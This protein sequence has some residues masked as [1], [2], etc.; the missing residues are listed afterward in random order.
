MMLKWSPSEGIQAT[1][2]LM[3]IITCDES[4]AVLAGAGAGKT[5]LLAQKA[6]YLF[7][8][9]QCVWPKRI[10]SLTF[11]VEAQLNIE[12]R[13]NKRCGHKA[14]R[15]DSFTFHSFSKSIVDRFK[16]VLPENE[17]PTDNYDIVFN[18]K[19]ANGKNK[20]LMDDLLS[21]AIRILRIR[22]DIRNVFP[23]SYSYVFV[24][25]FQDTTNEQYELLLLLFQNS[26]TKVLT[27]G[28][29]YQSIMLWA[30][31]REAVFTDFL[32]DFSAVRKFMVKNYRASKEIQDV[33]GTVLQYIKEPD[34]TVNELAAQSPNCSLHIFAD[35]HQ[36]ASIITANIKWLISTG[37]REDD[38]CILTKQQSSQ[39][40]EI[41]RAELTKLGINNLDMS[42]LQDTLKEPLGQLFS[43]FLKALVSP[44]P[45][46]MTEL[47][48]INLTLNKVEAGEDKEE[49][50][51]MCLVDFLS[52][53]K[54]LL[55]ANTTVDELISYAQGF[56]HFL[57][58]NKI[59]GRWQQYKSPEYYGLIWQRLEVHLRK[60]CIQTKSLEDA[61][62]LFN[63]ENSVH[64]MN[65]HKCKGLEYHAVYFLG[66]ED[67]AFWKYAD[68][69]F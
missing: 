16:N 52:S 22:T 68:E 34:K 53:K 9:D 26:D 49:E 13:V 51:T 15:F 7:F 47:Y 58:V 38:I 14:T 56:I 32:T 18:T 59:K 12:V 2:E 65:I 39:Y 63:A 60:V 27:V 17:R 45:K 37:V 42:E 61:T 5:E 62:R 69:P 35:E 20:V 33:L 67:Q 11:K 24:D 40:T 4:I 57:G 64:V 28:D 1:D 19:D 46:A 21:M 43:L 48:G 6:N 54:K 3:D 44:E 50:L 31:A 8:T 23:Y 30:G 66:L 36:E 25:E 41:L 29:I 55:T 10:L